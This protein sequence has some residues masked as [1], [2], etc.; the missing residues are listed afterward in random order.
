MLASPHPLATNS[1][2]NSFEKKNPQW[3]WV[4]WRLIE[5]EIMG[6]KP[7][8][9]KASPISYGFL[10]HFW[11]LLERDSAAYVENGEANEEVRVSTTA[12]S[13]FT[14]QNN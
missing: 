12:S 13:N 3:E 2:Q 9:F 6:E 7:C 8:W 11:R 5:T 10:N 1:K 14:L 4:K